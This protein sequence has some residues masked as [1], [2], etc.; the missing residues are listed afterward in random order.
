METDTYQFGLVLIVQ[1]VLCLIHELQY[2]AFIFIVQWLFFIYSKLLK[3]S[4]FP[5]LYQRNSIYATQ[6]GY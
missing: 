5:K 1:I 3:Y 4:I 6:F 2:K